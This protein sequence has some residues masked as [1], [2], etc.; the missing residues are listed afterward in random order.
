MAE[1]K[2]KR[3]TYATDFIETDIDRVTFLGN[4]HIDNIVTTLIAMGNEIWTD[5][6]RIRVLESLLAEKG[7]TAEMIEKYTPTTAQ[8]KAWAKEREILVDRFW[9]HF[10]RNTGEFTL[11]SD[12]QGK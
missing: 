10:S 2:S 6:K 7:V 8:E 5:R 4:A 1:P 3:A 9:S 11:T 12:W